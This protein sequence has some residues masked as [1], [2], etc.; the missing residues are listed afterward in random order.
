MGFATK[1]KAKKKSSQKEFYT[2]AAFETIIDNELN[3]GNDVIA[4][5]MYWIPSAVPEKASNTF[6]FKDNDVNI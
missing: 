1:E 3:N 2:C 6:M 4:A 5:L